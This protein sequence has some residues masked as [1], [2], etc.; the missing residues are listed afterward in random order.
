MTRPPTDL[1]RTH[2]RVPHDLGTA[3]TLAPHDTDVD[4]LRDTLSHPARTDPLAFPDLDSEQE[5]RMEDLLAAR[6]FPHQTAPQRI[7]RYTLFDRL[8]QGGMGVVYAAYDP[9]LD[10]RVAIK[11]LN[12]PL[13]QAEA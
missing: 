12:A 5:R 8:G 6:L 2:T 1:A 10:R 4:T 9:E 7:G 3:H 11:L 13:G